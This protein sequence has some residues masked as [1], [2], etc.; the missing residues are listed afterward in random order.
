M[1]NVETTR[2]F[3]PMPSSIGRP[4]QHRSSTPDV[5][6]RGPSRL[7]IGQNDRADT[8]ACRI[9]RQRATL[10][11]LAA[12][13]RPQQDRRSPVADRV[14]TSDARQGR[15]SALFGGRSTWPTRPCG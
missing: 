13:R 4:E 14:P 11:R 5:V 10:P 7:G 6:E 3:Q 15:K 8:S 1:A 9:V 12:V 2:H